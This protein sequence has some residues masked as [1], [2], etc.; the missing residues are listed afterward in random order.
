MKCVDSL[1]SWRIYFLPET[2][3]IEGDQITP[4]E[5]KRNQTLRFASSD[6]EAPL[7]AHF[8]VLLRRLSDE[9]TERERVSLSPQVGAS[10]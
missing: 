10:R 7:R 3:K 4:K 1:L 6:C 2:K 8:A 9:K 5:T